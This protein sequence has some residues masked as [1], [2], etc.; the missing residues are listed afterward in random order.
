MPSTWVTVFEAVAPPAPA[1]LE[2]AHKAVGQVLGS[3]DRLRSAPQDSLFAGN[4]NY[5]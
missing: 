5:R 2:A 1:R 3:G 4:E